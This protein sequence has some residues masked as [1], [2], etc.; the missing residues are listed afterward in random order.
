[1]DEVVRVWGEKGVRTRRLAVS[2]AFHSP[3]M[4]GV[5]GEFRRVLEGVEFGAPGIPVVSNVTGVVADAS[6]FGSAEYWVR[7]VREA[8]RFYDGVVHLR[9]Q[10]VTRF[11]ELGPDATL[12][13]L[14]QQ[15]LDDDHD[16]SVLPT[17]RRDQP[18]TDT[19]AKALGTLHTWGLRV[20][21]PTWFAGTE[22]RPVTLPTYAFQR[23]R[24]WMRADDG[25]A[26]TTAGPNDTGHPLLG[27][28]TAVAH[29]GD[30]LFTAR[31]LPDTHDWTADHA[32]LDAPVLPS[33]ALVEALT[34]M[35]DH[36]DAGTLRHLTVHRPLVLPGDG[37]A[38]LQIVVHA[39]D[40]SGRRPLSVHL[41]PD[42]AESPWT[43]HAEGELA[44]D[45]R[46]S[47]AGR[48][49]DDR[50]EVRLPDDLLPDAARYG[51]H[52]VLLEESV[53]DALG[54]APAGS[55]RFAERWEGV[56]VHTTGATV[57]RVLTEPGE[58]DS[59]SLR[60]LDTT[61]Q[62]VLTVDRL[63]FRDVPDD[64]F[65]PSDGRAL[66]LYT[67]A[68]QPLTPPPSTASPEGW[69]VVDSQDPKDPQGTEGMEGTASI[70]ALRFPDV[71]ALAAAMRDGAPVRH[72]LVE[73]AETGSTRRLIGQALT[74]V[75][76]WLAE[77]LLADTRLVVLTRGAVAVDAE[78]VDDPE[79]AAVWGLLRSAQTE[80]P[81]RIVL[82]DTDGAPVPDTVLAGLAASGEPQAALRSGTLL[83]PRLERVEQD[84]E[85]TAP[86]PWA[87]HGTVLVT[88]AG[89]AL[90]DVIARHLVA[91]HGVRHLLL[92]DD[93]ADGTWPG[94]ELLADLH[95]SG[96]DVTALACDTA[97]HAALRA[98]LT[99]IPE[100]RP[101]TAVVHT[102][103]L[104]DE[105][106]LS[107]LTP[108]RLQS[109]LRS[110][111]DTA[112]QLHELT[113]ELDLSAFVLC[114]SGAGAIGGAGRA[115]DSAT[116]AYLDG[117]AR[118]RTALG[119]P[120]TSLALGPWDQAAS[121][122]SPS[123]RLPLRELTA[124][125]GTDAFDAALRSDRPALVAVRLDGAALRAGAGLPA[126]LSSLVRTP[127][128]ARAAGAGSGTPAL[129]LAGL[130]VQERHQ[131]VLDLV[132][133]ESAAVLGHADA[134]A[135]AADRA[136]QELGFDSMTV[137]ELRNRITARTGIAL[138]ATLA[139]DHPSPAA[140]TEYL[141]AQLASEHEAASLSPVDGELRRLEALLRQAPED[142][143]ERHDIVVR[144]QT[145]LSR[146]TEAD[147]ERP[148][149]DLTGRIEAAS[150]EEIFAL[151]D[152]QL[153]G[154]T[155]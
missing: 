101:L 115:G 72:L 95:A 30:L 93:R 135:V 62:P 59:L 78:G 97:D 24:Y 22:A 110:T 147:E 152:D 37:A 10:G 14:T 4:E 98:A 47:A 113:R 13:A 81:E 146:L 140:L 103:A 114:T 27:H 63:T 83:V 102:A 32:V 107:E 67:M 122:G 91:E 96:A 64:R 45:D 79:A 55:T 50:G 33:S 11:V 136:F 7:H 16:V 123:T 145:L 46:P 60:L 148:S 129:S 75:Q 111:A 109:M 76:E 2:H 141:L 82:L 137:V 94:P 108:G 49:F 121:T 124:R 69:A 118:H 36:G 18:E 120:A 139:F 112:W 21:W 54:P 130:T 87:S 65:V 66:P 144:L 105:I 38:Q 19:L 119:L 40:D 44:P 68:W 29:T 104:P 89:G 43:L 150:A 131:T 17:L 57:V 151:I 74:L 42:D 99:A 85:D 143:A 134:G 8:V 153:G 90:A 138:S 86:S 88:G 84:T 5:L 133:A 149:A 132:R 28:R 6:E 100:H 9:E 61:G 15:A 58:A 52:P 31:V 1:M 155:D 39:E 34:R 128:R 56:R 142:A 51:L 106:A 26:A 116:A 53:R 154:S 71:P 12:T 92:L 127:G 20:D 48:G 126:V 23:E 41:R 70:D 35:A 3:H 73:F 80:A 125:D 25:G 117:L 77:P